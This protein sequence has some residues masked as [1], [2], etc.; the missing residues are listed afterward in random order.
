[1]TSLTPPVD[2]LKVIKR[3][4]REVDF[5]PELIN[6]AIANASKSLGQDG[7]KALA[8]AQSLTDDIV[9]TLVA[10]AKSTF[11]VEEIQDIV[12]ET[13]Q[14]YFPKVATTYQLYRQGR[15]NARE[16][17]SVENRIIS[18]IINTDSKNS[19]DKRENANMNCD[20]P[21]GSMYKIASEVSKEYYLRNLIRPEHVQMHNDGK[22]HIHDMDYFGTAINCMSS[23][24]GKLLRH[25]FCTGHGAI[26][27]PSSIGTAATLTCIVLQSNQNDMF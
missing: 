13:L 23:P 10:S 24:L 11:T 6:Q 2:N 25:G 17:K 18:E 27:P 15:T 26:R 9:A 7:E 19:D 12:V 21:S 3:D 20:T 16:L 5:R 8:Q 1:M 14:T 22:I 4:G